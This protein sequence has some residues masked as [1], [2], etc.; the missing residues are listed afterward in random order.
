[1]EKLSTLK[2]NKAPGLDSIHSYVLKACAHTLCTPLTMLFHQSL[3]SGDLPCE[4]KKAH[5]IPVYKKGSKF[6]ATNYRP[7]SLTSTVVK[8]LESIIR[9]E[10]FDFLLEN[11]ILNHQ[12]HGFVCNKSC[13]TNLLETFEDW[14]SA[15]DQGYGVDVVYLDYSKAFDSVPHRRLISKLE[16]Y[17]VRG[18]LSLWLSNFLTNRFQRVV[19]NGSQSDWVNVQ[20]GVPQGSVL[21]PLLFILYVSNVPDLIESNLKMFA[22]DTKIYSVI[23]S[24]HD[25]LK[26]QHD[27]NKLMQWSS[28][29]LLRFNAAK[30]KVMQ[31]GNSLPASYTMYNGTTNVSTDLELVNEE[32]DLGVWCTSDLKPSLHCQKAAVKATQVLGLI[33][34]SFRIDSTDMFIFL[35]K[36]YVRPHLEY[37]V[38]SWSPYLARDIDT[39]EKVQRRATKHLRGL[40]HLTYESRLEILDLYSLYCRRQRGDMIETYKILKRHYDLDPSTFFTLNTATTRGHSLKLFKERSRLLVRQNFFTNRIVNLWNSLPDFIISAPTVATFKLRLDNF[41]KQSRYGHLQRPAA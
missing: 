38:Q 30:C 29:W 3:T 26:L 34:R 13:L 27:I 4:W 15:V 37:C 41:W 20:S 14:T 11:N 31:I 17:G 22:D 23:K 35:Y 33:R 12:Q 39:L 2:D 10:L 6:K 28:V 25:S 8:I 1:M 16:A 19:V 24:F 9:T 18:N 32:K 5:V 7:I 21:G 36:M 40:A